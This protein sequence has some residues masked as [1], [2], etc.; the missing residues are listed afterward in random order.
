[1]DQFIQYRTKVLVVSEQNTQTESRETEILAKSPKL[2]M[3][4]IN[5]LIDRNRTI[6]R[7]K[8]RKK[9]LNTNMIV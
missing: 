1:M 3:R 9:E 6:I 5:R 7:K 2:V 4:S 8:E